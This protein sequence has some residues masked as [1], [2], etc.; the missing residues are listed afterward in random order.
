MTLKT[1]VDNV[2]T[3][4]EI[5]EKTQNLELKSTIIDLKEQILELREENLELK[6][7]LSKQQEYN[8]VF[9]DNC[10]WNYKE[11]GT[12]EGPYCSACWDGKDKAIRMKIDSNY[13]QCTNCKNNHQHTPLNYNGLRQF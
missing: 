6:Q 12:K 3:I 11:D 2:K 8:M 13:Y 5:A 4:Q 7:S 9:E 10:Y 1:I